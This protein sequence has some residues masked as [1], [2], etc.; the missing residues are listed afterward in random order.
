MSSTQLK[1]NEDE[2]VSGATE[3]IRKNTKMHFRKSQK[4]VLSSVISFSN[5]SSGCGME[6]EDETTERTCFS[7]CEFE[8]YLKGK[9]QRVNLSLYLKQKE[10]EQRDS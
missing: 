3:N 10:R 1:K 7:D 6:D 9:N 4:N 5:V 8:P 2:L